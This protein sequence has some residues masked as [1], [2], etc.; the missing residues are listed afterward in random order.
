MQS[1][2]T[3]D[4]RE[5]WIATAILSN[6][7]R[8]VKD[9]HNFSHMRI[10][11]G[12]YVDEDNRGFLTGCLADAIFNNSS[13]FKKLSLNFYG[14]L[15]NK[16]HENSFLAFN[17]NNGNFVVIVKGSNAYKLLLRGVEAMFPEVATIEHSDLDIAVFI[18]PYLHADLFAKI[19]DSVIICVSQVMA[20]YKK[21]LDNM[22]FSA[23]YD[24]NG[25]WSVEDVEAFKAAYNEAVEDKGNDEEGYFVSPFKDNMARNEC[26]RRSFLI[27]KS[28][29]KGT[30]V[31]VEVPHLNKCERIP[32]KKTPFVVSH[33]NTISFVRDK[34]GFYN[35]EFDLIRLRLNNLLVTEARNKVVP[36]DF[37]DVSIPSHNDAQLYDF[38]RRRSIMRCVPIFDEDTSVHVIVPNLDECIHDLH[39]M[40]HVYDNNQIKVEK[41]K[42]RMDMFMSIKE[43]L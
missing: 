41:R 27:R 31:R 5:A 26:S 4:D 19:R 38:W 29:E 25:M 20:R 1:I 42:E 34:E 14:D 40:L 21:E 17:Y 22:F 16:I 18:N 28:P 35:G 37:I 15:L 2:W 12:A 39:M 8:G 30:I 10:E 23:G 13:V 43:G 32:L 36:A 9:G 24:G 33:N 3:H 11:Q 6:E 7:D